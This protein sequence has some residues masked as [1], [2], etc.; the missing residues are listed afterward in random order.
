MANEKRYDFVTSTR[1]GE[2]T[3]KIGGKDIFGAVVTAV[4]FA[5]A[6]PIVRKT[7]DGNQITEITLA[8]NNTGKR[9]TGSVGLGE[10]A[11]ETLWLKATA[12]DNG[13]FNLA[14]RLA[15]V[16]RKG[17]QVAVSGLL[18]TTEYNGK[19]QYQL[20]INDF[21]VLWS[22]DKGHSYNSSYSWIS[23]RKA[24]KE[25]QAIAAFRGKIS[26]D[27]EVKVISDGQNEILTF[28]VPLS[29]IGTKLNYS[30][31]IAGKAEDTTWL[32]VNVWNN[33][34][35][36][37]KDRAEKILRKGSTLIGHGIVTTTV[38]ENGKTYYNMN[39][40]DFTLTSDGKGKQESK[41]QDFQE[42][43]EQEADDFY[44]GQPIDI[45]DDDLPF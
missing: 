32:Q 21:D 12:F 14:T 27:P 17:T 25:G 3:G 43:E 28:S 36:N 20:T 11:G 33:E 45:L 15:K 29:K 41:E 2:T 30:L 6:E 10:D 8:L 34:G 39:L 24:N 7:N 22:S 23:A 38:G 4:G 19:P 9:I 35:F 40:S 1:V 37:L 13:A 44:Q 31:G 16:V 42:P 26:K 5:T 18:K